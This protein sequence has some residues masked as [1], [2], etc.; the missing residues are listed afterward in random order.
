MNDNILIDAANSWKD[1]INYEYLITYGYKNK[2]YNIKLSFHPEEFYHLAGFQYL[3]DLN[4]PRY[5]SRVIL[6]RIIEGKIKNEQKEQQGKGFIISVTVCALYR[7]RG[8]VWTHIIT[9]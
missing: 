1:L 5:N 2:L 7:D 8:T 3:K 4:L 9:G 6:D